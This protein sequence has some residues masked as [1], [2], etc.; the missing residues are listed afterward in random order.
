[1][2][3]LYAAKKDV[4]FV[5]QGIGN[6]KP[7]SFQI[8]VVPNYDYEG[9]YNET[10][11]KEGYG[12]SDFID[13]EQS[14]AYFS[15]VN[16]I[17]IPDEIKSYFDSNLEYAGEKLNPFDAVG[18]IRQYLENNIEYDENVDAPDLSGDFVL[19]LLNNSKKGYSVHF[20]T[21]AAL[22]FR[23]YGIPARYVEGYLATPD[24]GETSFDLADNDAHAWV[25]IYVN[26][27]G[28]IPIEVTPGFY[29]NESAGG[30]SSSGGGSSGNSGGSSNSDM[31]NNQENM[32]DDLPPVVTFER[33]IIVLAVI[34][35]ICVLAVIIR[36]IIII[37]KRD[38]ILYG[39]DMEKVVALSGECMLRLMDFRHRKLEEQIEP[40]FK[41]LLERLKFGSAP[42]THDEASIV[43]DNALVMIRNTYQTE[44]LKG[45]IIL[46]YVLCLT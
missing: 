38:K 8:D 11:Y 34:I 10:W 23:Y 27:L 9:I 6:S 1:L 31:D 16:Y 32:K 12:D 35:C 42:P 24:E 5:A 3:N 15:N 45:K 41:M 17:E 19:S 18:V 28:F 29:T 46:R 36:R 40:E 39:E 43:R 33:I 4:N 44:K 14:Y 22:M 25:E 20:A 2:S 30:S 13:C 37:R 7:Y 26:G 21:V